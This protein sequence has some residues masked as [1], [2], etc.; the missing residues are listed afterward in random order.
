[1]EALIKY[2]VLTIRRP[3]FDPSYIDAHYGFLGE[4]RERGVLEQAGPFTDKSGGA[5]VVLAGS[6]DEARRIAE[7]DPLH[8]HDCSAVTVHEW[9]AA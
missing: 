3:S 5:Y 7:Q 2:L 4:L 1:M 9:N 6:L 8:L